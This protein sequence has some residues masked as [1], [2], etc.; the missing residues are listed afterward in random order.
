MICCNFLYLH[1]KQHGF[2]LNLVEIPVGNQPK[3]FYEL[4]ARVVRDSPN[5]DLQK[6]F[7]AM[8]KEVE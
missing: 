1:E 7:T 8:Q 4:L 6:V 5:I 2:A 3:Q